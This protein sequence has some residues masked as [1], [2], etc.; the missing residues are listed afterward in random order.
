[1]Q[2]Q[3]QLW[4]FHALTPLHAG[5]GSGGAGIVDLPVA[6]EKAT[7]WPIVPA[8]SIKGTL[9]SFYSGEDIKRLFGES[10]N[11]GTLVFSDARL[12]ALPVRSYAG[13]FAY[14]TSALLLERLTRDSKALGVDF[15]A[16]V[17]APNDQ[18]LSIAPDSELAWQDKVVLND[19]SF[20]GRKDAAT[21][22]R[23]SALAQRIF[24]S[25]DEQRMFV[26]RFA[27]VPDDAFD[28]LCENATEVVA[29]IALEADTKNVKKGGLWYEETVPAEA[30]FALFVR[31]DKSDLPLLQCFDDQTIQLGGDASIG[32]GLCRLKT[33]GA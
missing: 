31:G 20:T 30:V 18:Q 19:L 27:V 14:C 16:D 22:A 13:T 25:E 23:A 21:G 33:G 32:R 5:V 17:T 8:S 15:S 4:F 11:G 10:D 26:E 28:F 6:R 9:R 1:M 3:T 24:K 7:G 12:L 2:M 29:R